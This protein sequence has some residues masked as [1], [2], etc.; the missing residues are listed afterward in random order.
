MILPLAIDIATI[1]KIIIFLVIL[2]SW[3][4]RAV[5][6][7]Q[8]ATKARRQVRE[9][10]ARRPPLPIDPMEEPAVRGPRAEAAAPVL[11]AEAQ[12]ARPNDKQI[13]DEVDE[14]LRNA[15]RER[16]AEKPPEPPRP[17]RIEIIDE[18]AADNPKP[19]RLIDREQHADIVDS[20]LQEARMLGKGSDVARHVA[21]H[22]TAGRLGEHAA[23]LGHDI[24]QTDE[25]L[26]ARLKAKFNHRLGR[27]DD[28]NDP[29]PTATRNR[30]ASPLA[31]EIL[32]LMQSP[33]GVRQ[34]IVLNEILT[35][36]AD[37]W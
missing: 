7:A 35:R 33:E 1:V 14:F 28:G 20:R 2:A 26:E 24:E 18:P 30:E 37:R 23:Q 16:P 27:L 19:R 3:V 6:E 4:L 9:R 13:R 31:A 12:A 11:L 21:E 29:S 22:L 25:R 34:A 15:G 36:P 32:D 17:S 10:K 5:S 8:E